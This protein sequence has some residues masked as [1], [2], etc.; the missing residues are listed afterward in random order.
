MILA[1]V[2]SPGLTH[3]LQSKRGPASPWATVWQ[4]SKLRSPGKAGGRGDHIDGPLLAGMHSPHPPCR[5]L[6]RS[7]PSENEGPLGG[8]QCWVSSVGVAPAARDSKVREKLQAS[9]QNGSPGT[10]PKD[11]AAVSVSR[12]FSVHLLGMMSLQLLTQTYAN[13]SSESPEVLLVPP[14]LTWPWPWGPRPPA[15]P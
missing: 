13:Q 3:A 14:G 5:D 8:K 1:R 7:P 9:H 2:H 10:H 4:K 15:R 6:G 12:G 11:S